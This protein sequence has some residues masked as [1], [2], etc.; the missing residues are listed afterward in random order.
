MLDRRDARCVHAA[1]SIPIGADLYTEVRA[2][3]STVK[4]AEICEGDAS[5]LLN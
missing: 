3:A 5:S 2:I 4:K 1:E